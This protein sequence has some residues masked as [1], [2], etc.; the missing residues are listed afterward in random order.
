V[1]Q[2][3]L[4]LLDSHLKPLHA[5]IDRHESLLAEWSRRISDLAG[6]VKDLERNEEVHK[7]EI[8]QGLASIRS[9]LTRA[10]RAARD[11]GIIEE[12]EA[13]DDEPPEVQTAP[14]R[15]DATRAVRSRMQGRTVL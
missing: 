4:E 10:N 11:T 6:Q 13:I 12:E 2:R 15:D 14:T 9:L 7:T 5:T 3:D 8:A 1:R